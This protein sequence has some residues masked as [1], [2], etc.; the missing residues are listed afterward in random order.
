MAAAYRQDACRRKARWI[1]GN[2]FEVL[3]VRHCAGRLREAWTK[4][5]NKLAPLRGGICSTLWGLVFLCFQSTGFEPGAWGERHGDVFCF[6]FP[7]ARFF[8]FAPQAM[9]CMSLRSV[10]VF[11]FEAPKRNQKPVWLSHTGRTL[12]AEMLAGFRA[13]MVMYLRLVV[14]PGALIHRGP[15]LV[16]SGRGFSG[17][18]QVCSAWHNSHRSIR[19]PAEKGAH[20]RDCR[21]LG[22]GNYKGPLRV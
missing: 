3:E 18:G 16:F 19:H 14:A 21:S 20:K 22:E 11:L 13:M 5:K 8:G 6:E 4:P 17:P 7:S 10:V 9:S 15:A 2:D 1:P 12:V